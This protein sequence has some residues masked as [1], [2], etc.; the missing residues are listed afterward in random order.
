MKVAELT[1]DELKFVIKD[2]IEEKMMEMFIDPDE[3]LELKEA[4]KER[5]KSSLDSV[6][7]GKRGLS[8]SEVAKK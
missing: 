5:L 4:L 6:R 3:G 2:T 1:I 8:A 7:Q